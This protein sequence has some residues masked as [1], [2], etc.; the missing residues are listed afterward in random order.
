MKDFYKLIFIILSII[1]ITSCTEDE[2]PEIEIVDTDISVTSETNMIFW[3]DDEDLNQKL[4]DNLIYNFGE[5]LESEIE[6]KLVFNS[7]STQVTASI[8][9]KEQYQQKYF[10]LDISNNST[11]LFLQN[12]N[13]ILVDSDIM[14]ALTSNQLCELLQALIN[15]LPNFDLNSQGFVCIP[16]TFHIPEG[17]TIFSNNIDRAINNLNQSFFDSKVLFSLSGV[18][19]I[20]NNFYNLDID[21]TTNYPDVINN[22]NVY[23][24]HT[25]STDDLQ[26]GQTLNGLAH[27]PTEFIDRVYVR[28]AYFNPN[29]DEF[30]ALLSHEVGH[31]FSLFHTFETAADNS[32]CNTNGVIAGDGIADTP[33]DDYNGD[34]LIHYGLICNAV[35]PTIREL[36]DN[37]MSYSIN[38]YTLRNCDRL[39]TPLQQNRIGFSARQWKQHLSCENNGGSSNIQISGDINFGNVP[40]NTNSSIETL[41]VSNNGN[42]NFVITSISSN[43]DAFVILNPQNLTIEPN[44][45][46]DFNIR[47]NPTSIQNYQG[48]ITI[49]NNADNSNNSNS[50][51]NVEGNGTTGNSDSSIISLSG[52]LNFGGVTIGNTTTRTL[53]IANEGNQPLSV[54][55][56]IFPFNVYTTSWSS[57]TI[58]G[59]NSQNVTVTFQPTGEQTYNGTVTVNS[60]ADEGTNTINISGNG[61][62]SNNSIISLSGNLN[63]GA[64]NI[65][66]NQARVLT[67]SNNGN[68][69]FNVSGINLP[70]NEYSSDWNSGA[71]PAGG[72]QNVNITFAPTNQQSYNGTV[73]VDNNADSGSGNI[74]ISGN[75]IDNNT[76]IISLSGNLNFG[77]VNIGQNQSRVL[78]ISNN[79]NESFNVSGINLPLNEYSSDWNSG[80]IRAGGSQNVNILFQPTNEQ[81]YNGTLIVN[82]NADSGNNTISISG[83]GINNNQNVVLSYND[84]LV[85]DGNGGGNGNSNG[86]A[87][88][89]EEI[90]LD[91]QLINTGNSTATNVSATLTSNDPDITIT[92]DFESWADIPAGAIEWEDD[93]DFDIDPNCPTKNVTFNL[94]INSDQ[95]T[96]NE[97]FTINIQGSSGGNSQVDVGNNTPRENCSDTGSSNNYELDLNTVYYKENWNI[98]NIISYGSDGYR[99]M[100][101]RFTTNNSG[102]YVIGV[103]FTGGNAG[104]QLFSSCYSSSPIITSNSS[105]GDGEVAQL[106]LN[107]NTEY[108][109]RFYDINDNNPV[110]FGVIIGN[111]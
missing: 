1:L 101:Y 104:F 49:D 75:G 110:T 109:I 43:N 45:S 97:T 14:N 20:N 90:D 96:W 66:Q 15:D 74:S 48:V 13:E 67:I 52:N 41:T 81:S 3:I 105:D 50:A 36:I 55:N 88:A 78:T 98:N 71:I 38:N 40:V 17:I 44:Q 100:W 59:E 99:G 70:F 63:F 69:S 47:F 62:V 9:F 29:R 73:I 23:V 94:Q 28:D 86:I 77:A 27:F 72:S 51:I 64:V 111:N 85:K 79:G 60:D 89:G 102:L 4:N 92:D 46:F 53:T 30:S 107:S 8:N 6:K 19:T 24:A 16:V 82:N 7:D 37:F 33:F 91:V 56:I 18:N 103:S 12:E 34:G 76:S 61:V 84:N 95:G 11:S 93:F 21:D 83:N 80:N 58:N 31:F 35:N 108:F 26:P 87:E 68:E 57:G 10:D 39:F 32:T 2:E 65:G 5:A 54:G 25:L 42:V 106:N 22:L